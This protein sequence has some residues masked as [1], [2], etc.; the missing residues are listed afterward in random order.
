[1][2]KFI[3]RKLLIVKRQP[4]DDGYNI[5]TEIGSQTKTYQITEFEAELILSKC[6]D[7][8]IEVIVQRGLTASL[9]VK[10]GD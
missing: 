2:S 8:I 4:P 3:P 10:K 9:T 5:M 6:Y 7:V 1:M